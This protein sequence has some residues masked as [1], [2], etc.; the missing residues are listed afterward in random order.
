V[1]A[2]SRRRKIEKKKA[3]EAEKKKDKS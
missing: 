2:A 3:R 1:T